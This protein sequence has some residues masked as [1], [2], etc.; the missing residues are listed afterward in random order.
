M[1]VEDTAKKDILDWGASCHAHAVPGSLW[2]YLALVPRVIF[3]FF[4][5]LRG[6]EP[7]RM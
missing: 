1:G 3:F 4:Y 5:H 6:A 7:L 2:G